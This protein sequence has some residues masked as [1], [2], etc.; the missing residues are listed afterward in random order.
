MTTAMATVILVK[1]H[2]KYNAHNTKTD[3]NKHHGN[4]PYFNRPPNPAATAIPICQAGPVSIHAPAP[5][6]ASRIGRVNSFW[7]RCPGYNPLRV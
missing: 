5:A 1:S 2:F 7:L 3:V 4:A 6:A